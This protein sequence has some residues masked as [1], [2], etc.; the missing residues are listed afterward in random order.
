MNL[1]HNTVIVFEDLSQSTDSLFFGEFVHQ[2]TRSEAW[3]SYT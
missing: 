3:T 2:S 1:P